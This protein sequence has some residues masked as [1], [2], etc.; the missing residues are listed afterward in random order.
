MGPDLHSAEEYF[1]TLLR[2]ARA[3]EGEG[4]YAIAAAV[5]LRHEGWELLVVGTNSVFAG[6]N[7]LGHAE[8]NAVMHLRKL[9]STDRDPL[10]Q[11]LADGE[12]DGSI[13]VRQAPNDRSETVLYTT[14]EPCPMCTVCIINAGIDRVVIAADDPPSGSLAP[15]RLAALPPIWPEL[16][17]GL[18]VMWAQSDD[19][20][21]FESYLPE[22]LRSELVSVF[23]DSR[24]RFDSQLSDHGALD[25]NALGKIA[26][27]AG[28]EH[29]SRV[30]S[31]ASSV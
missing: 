15:E 2:R 24:V 19:P 6:H 21:A 10:E 22:S 25:L 29:A 23:V 16:A 1:S 7:P 28:R 13:L 27:A 11:M 31:T 26:V 12:A 9:G 18:T 8:A 20:S 5:S 14:L 4:N 3:T 30:A 17:R